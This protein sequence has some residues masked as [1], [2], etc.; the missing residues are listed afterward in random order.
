MVMMKVLVVDREKAERQAIVEA[1]VELDG[2]TV[3]GA[4]PD[5]EGALRAIAECSPDIVVT[6]TGLADQLVE[7]VRRRERSPSIV[8]VGRD[9]PRAEWKRHLEAGADRFVECDPGFDELRDVVGSLVNRP[10]PSQA[11]V[12]LKVIGRMAVGVAHEVS[13]QLSAIGMTLA[14]LE[15]APHD[16][17]LWSD[18][19]SAIEQSS[20]LVSTLLGYVPG[21]RPGAT[22]L[23]LGGVVRSAL[24]RAGR[25]LGPN[26]S[27]STEI[28][29]GLPSLRGVVQ[30]LEQLV[31][32]LVLDA[33]D[34]MPDGGE[35]IVRVVPT[36]ASAV[37]LEIA[38]TGTPGPEG[39]RHEVMAAILRRHQAV[40][41]TTK[42]EPIGAITR[43][44]LP[45]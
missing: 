8:V 16:K 40:M 28:R 1:L 23:E 30:E 7:A 29:T 6:G 22:D 31:V 18:A 32:D 37:M 20:R 34:A 11:D 39:A 10:R 14:M 5:F 19:H 17:Q 44:M 3:Q 42:R 21:Q 12:T 25:L 38:H 27:V 4:V 13:L 36:A 33:N 24:G 45:V 26:V 15:R 9:T 43:V 41:R 35:L 2:I